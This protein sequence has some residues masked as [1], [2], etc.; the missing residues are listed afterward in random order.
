MNTTT[1]EE[2]LNRR[3]RIVFT[4]VGKSMMPL[5]RQGRD[6]MVIEKKGPERY[7]K[8]DAVLFKRDNGQYVLHRILEVREKDYLI[9]GDNCYQKEYVDDSHILGI[10]KEVVRDGKT[11]SVEDTGYQ[12]YVRLWCGCFPLR[13]GLLR[14]RHTV[15]KA[16][17]KIKAR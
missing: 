4:N 1:F 2:E 12:R 8:Y 6:L 9:V 10:L 17:R 16:L 15:G 5:L 13:A 14:A 11:I 7:R 3:G